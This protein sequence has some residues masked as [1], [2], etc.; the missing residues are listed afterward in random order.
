MTRIVQIFF[1]G[2]ANLPA[3]VWL[4]AGLFLLPVPIALLLRPAGDVGPDPARVRRLRWSLFVVAVLYTFLHL[5]FFIFS[6]HLLG[7]S[8]SLTGWWSMG[9]MGPFIV[10]PWVSLGI[11][12][13]VLRFGR[14]DP[15]AGIS[16]RTASLVPRGSNPVVRRI[17][18]AFSWGC[19]A[20]CGLVF[21]VVKWSGLTAISSLISWFLFGVGGIMLLGGPSIVRRALEIEAE[22]LDGDVTNRERL[23]DLYQK[24]RQAN[25]WMN[26]RIVCG[27]VAVNLLLAWQNLDGP[28][29][30]ELI[31]YPVFLCFAWF[32]VEFTAYFARRRRLQAIREFLGSSPK[33]R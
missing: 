24:N 8:Y 9:P 11:L 1:S 19:W 10:V 33:S 22:P 12:W 16:R 3:S 2:L 7:G 6:G 15:L 18:W 23:Q 17:H 28:H 31:L 29:W 5:G 25:A 30:R 14:R 13:R 27:V 4:V 32:V 20:A 26:Y 21:G